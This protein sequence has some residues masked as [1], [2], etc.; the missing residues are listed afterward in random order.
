LR[1]AW[2]FYEKAL[3]VF[4]MLALPASAR[5]NKKAPIFQSMLCV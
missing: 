5:K 4:Q 2:R 3:V 1:G